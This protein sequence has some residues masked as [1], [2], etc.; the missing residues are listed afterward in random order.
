ML[1]GRS[2][3]PGQRGVTLLE[4]MVTVSMVGILLAIGV[5][6]MADWIR[7]SSVRGAAESVQNGL[8]QALAEAVRRNHRVEFLLTNGTPSLSGIRTLT[9]TANGKNWAA[10]VLGAD[11]LPLATP[12]DAY[13]GSFAMQEIAADVS[14]G[15]P[16][17]LVFNGNGR[18]QALDGTAPSTPQVFRISRTGADK[19]YCVFVTPGGGIKMCDPSSPSGNPAACAP[20]LAADLCAGP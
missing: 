19:V 8:R 16:A 10:R 13:V 20:Q 15:G 7:R 14:V 3:R 9:S 12:A 2:R 11:N 18:V 17:N 1:T 4:L 5:P 6:N